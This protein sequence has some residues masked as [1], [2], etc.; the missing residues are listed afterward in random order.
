[1]SSHKINVQNGDDDVPLDDDVDVL[2]PAAPP[3]SVPFPLLDDDDA[4]V[5]LPKQGQD[6]TGQS[7]AE[8]KTRD[9]TEDRGKGTG[10]DRT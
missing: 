8:D 3:S 2:I 7:R 9:A 4:N 6:K 10:Q 1:M 5:P